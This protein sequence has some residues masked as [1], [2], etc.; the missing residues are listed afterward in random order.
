MINSGC[1]SQRALC[2][3]WWKWA[4]SLLR[5]WF[6]KN[7]FSVFLMNLIRDF[8]RH[9]CMKLPT[10]SSGQRPFCACPEFFG[11]QWC[12]WSHWGFWFLPIRQRSANRALRNP[13]E[14]ALVLHKHS[15]AFAL[16]ACTCPV[17][18]CS[19]SWG[20]L[21]VVS[22]ES[23]NMHILNI[24]INMKGSCWL[25]ESSGADAG[26]SAV[27]LGAAGSWSPAAEPEQ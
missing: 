23:Q 26:S 20:V 5:S 9:G 19:S 2:F 27:P 3:G 18:S 14:P 17:L 16:L 15:Y 1:Q 12:S 8:S 7:G 6:T 4:C 11:A 25:L 21:S 22:S 24:A 10:S 13:R